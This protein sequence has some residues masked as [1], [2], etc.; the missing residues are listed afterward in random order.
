M[1]LTPSEM[2]LI[3]EFADSKPAVQSQARVRW[4]LSEAYQ[5]QLVSKYRDLH[6]YY[7]PL[8]QD[9]WPQDKTLRPGKIH[10]TSNLCK[11]AVDVDARLQ[12]IPPRITIPVAT[13]TPDE[14]K[15]AEAAEALLLL[16]LDLSGFDTWL[17]VL[18]QIK[19]IYGKGILKPGEEELA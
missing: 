16:W 13:L 10:T 14:R 2:Q 8:D 19:S 3:E 6:H 7:N 18:C 9:H 17:N 1:A 12:S 5:S 4:S 15:R 11:A